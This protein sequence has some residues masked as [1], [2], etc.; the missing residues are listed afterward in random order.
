[1]SLNTHKQYSHGYKNEGF[2]Q[3][4]TPP[5]IL[6]R[7]GMFP[8]PSVWEHDRKCHSFLRLSLPPIVCTGAALCQPLICGSALGLLDRSTVS[9]AVK[10]SEQ[11]PEF[12]YIYIRYYLRVEQLGHLVNSMFNFFRNCQIVFHSG[13]TI[14][15]SQQ[16]Q[17]RGFHFSISQ[18]KNSV[19]YFFSRPI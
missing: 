16:Q 15:H 19:C 12:T 18:P 6:E 2:L 1:M 9:D 13:C 11:V 8:G 17:M 7:Q 3:Y 10:V 5:Q 14:S 4:L